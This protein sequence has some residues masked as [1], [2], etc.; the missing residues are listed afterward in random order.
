M[1]Y[2]AK[3]LLYRTS[4]MWGIVLTAGCATSPETGSS[5]TASSAYAALGYEYLTLEATPRARQAFEKAYAYHPSDPA[6]LHGLALC[7]HFDQMWRDAERWYKAAQ[8][9]AQRD[10]ATN[11]Q[12]QIAHNYASL[13]YDTE[14]YDD[15]CQIWQTHRRRP[16]RTDSI[17]CPYTRE[18]RRMTP[19]VQG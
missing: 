4:V 13:L 12:A 15:A 9:A 17:P 6:T 7:A 16:E 3:A 19:N 14:R 2:W 18:A 5:R 8:R 1:P 10:S 11:Q